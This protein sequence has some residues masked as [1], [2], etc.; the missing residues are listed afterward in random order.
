MASRDDD[1]V[2]RL[3]VDIDVKKAIRD[4]ARLQ[5]DMFRVVGG[6][7]K[8][9]GQFGKANDRMTQDSI[10]GTEEWTNAVG[11]LT[12]AWSKGDKV[13]QALQNKLKNVHGDERVALQEELELAK[14][15]NAERNTF[16]PKKTTRAQRDAAHEKG[17]GIKSH[18]DRQDGTKALYKE[19]GESFKSGISSLFGK[20]PRA[21]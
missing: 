19:A 9:M 8:R 14:Q 12:S 20:M 4:M 18:R 21:R 5:K 15:L 10:K 11:D 2:I 17:G 7:E 1:D 16:K 13:V 6:L 3:G